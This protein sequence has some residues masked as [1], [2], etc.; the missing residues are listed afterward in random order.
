M[1]V[2]S[3]TVGHNFSDCSSDSEISPTVVGVAGAL[4]CHDSRLCLMVVWEERYGSDRWDVLSKAGFCVWRVILEFS[5][6]AEGS[7][8]VC[9]M[10]AM[11]TQNKHDRSLKEAR[12][13]H[14]PFGENE[15]APKG[16]VANLFVGSN[17]ILYVLYEFC[18]SVV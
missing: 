17:F 14:Q 6:Y 16:C 11:Y 15:A 2:S 12:A 4:C 18:I 5:N 3:R 8:D 10:C 13:I 9:E 7:Q 1:V